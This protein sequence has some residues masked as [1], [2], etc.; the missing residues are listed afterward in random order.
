MGHGYVFVSWIS[1][2]CKHCLVHWF[3][4][5]RIPCQ[6]KFFVILTSKLPF[7]QGEPDCVVFQ[8]H[9]DENSVGTMGRGVPVDMST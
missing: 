4:I 2:I 7:D 9:Y 1:G 3:T 5:L 8:K 6:N